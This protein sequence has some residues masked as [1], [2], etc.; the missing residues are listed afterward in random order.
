M[1]ASEVSITTD[2]QCRVNNKWLSSMMAEKVARVIVH[3][4]QSTSRVPAAFGWQGES[5]NLS[6]HRAASISIS[7]FI[8]IN[9]TLTSSV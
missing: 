5:C 7:L 1:A 3:Y 9:L 4:S 2:Y 6:S 8:A